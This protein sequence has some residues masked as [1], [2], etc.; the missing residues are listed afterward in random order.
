MYWSEILINIWKYVNPLTVAL[1]I[2]VTGVYGMNKIISHFL[3]IYLFVWIFSFPI[4]LLIVNRFI[5][6]CIVLCPY[7]NRLYKARKTL[8]G[9]TCATCSFCKGKVILNENCKTYTYGSTD[10]S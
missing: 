2:A 1:I 8:A 6:D 9:N 5:I 7:C 3:I 10:K 4:S